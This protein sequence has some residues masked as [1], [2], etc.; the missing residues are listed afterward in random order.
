[1]GGP[2]MGKGGA[3]VGPPTK[4]ATLPDPRKRKMLGRGKIELGPAP[5]KFAACRPTAGVN[6]P[7]KKRSSLLEK[8]SSLHRLCL[9]P[10]FV[11]V[12]KPP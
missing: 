11:R 1:M 8:A 6:F 9:R 3:R 7:P 5:H 2:H 4:A 10:D 12:G